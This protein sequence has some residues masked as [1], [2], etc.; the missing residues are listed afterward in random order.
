MIGEQRR[1]DKHNGCEIKLSLMF[2]QEQNRKD[3]KLEWE[4]LEKI[5]AG[6]SK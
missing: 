1:V 3:W 4:N 5:N 2:Q 6:S